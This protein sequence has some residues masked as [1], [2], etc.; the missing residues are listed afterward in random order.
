LGRESAGDGSARAPIQCS[1]RICQ[2]GDVCDSAVPGEARRSLD[3]GEHAPAA[4]LSAPGQAPRLARG[5][6][7][8]ELG[9]VAPE[10]AVDAVDVGQ[11]QQAIGSN[12]RCE[13][14]CCEIL[15]DD[16]LDAS[17]AAVGV[18]DHRHATAAAR[19]DHEPEIGEATHGIVLEQALRLR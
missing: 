14:D 7:F 15:V 18:D 1:A 19:N 12:R 2:R 8:Q 4:E 3:L 5:E 6:P 13:Y 10:P 16:R 11:E 9:S 17:R